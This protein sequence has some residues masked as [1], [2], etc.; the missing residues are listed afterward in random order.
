MMELTGPLHFYQLAS[1]INPQF[2]VTMTSQNFQHILSWEAGSNTTVPT[3]YQVKYSS[4]R[5]GEFQIAE[6]C[7][8]ITHLFCDLSE[9]FT[10]EHENYKAMV[11]GFTG[12]KVFTSSTCCL[13]PYLDTSLGPPALNITP[14]P[15]SINITITLPAS[16]LKREGKVLSLIDIY[17]E[18]KY[19]ITVRTSDAQVV[20]LKNT[21]TKEHFATVVEG[22]YPNANYCV[23]VAVTAHLKDKSIPSTLKCVITGSIS[24]QG[25]PAVS[26]IG[27]VLVALVVCVI[28]FIL[29]R[30]GIIRLKTKKWPSVLK[31]TRNLGYSVCEPEPE[32]VSPVQVV[33]QDIKKKVWDYNYGGDDDDEDDDNDT[34]NNGVY[35]MHGIIHRYSGDHAEQNI[36]VKQSMDCI[37]IESIS[38]SNELLDTDVENSGEQQISI[39]K[40]ED[41]SAEESCHPS[42]EENCSMASVSRNSTCFNINL[43]T[44]MLGDLEKPWDDTSPLISHQEDADDLPE[45]GDSDALESKLFTDAVDVQKPDCHNISHEWQKSSFS[46]ESDLSDSGTDQ[47]TEYIGR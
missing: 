10:D 44:V 32:N 41:T 40:N 3:Y 31:T 37:S 33:F 11:Q 2:N 43:N 36:S 14:Y 30:A 20:T 9:Y 38:Q 35:T 27:G 23:S 6:E 12:S 29:H 17:D 4:F 22:L 34:G 15:S 24:Q 47:V 5:S 1:V 26:I 16:H 21:T 25:Y 46:D 8:N 39:K 18:L 13:I 45:C 28:L 7:S 19:V 42:D